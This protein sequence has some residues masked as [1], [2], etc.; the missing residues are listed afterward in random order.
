MCSN[1]LVLFQTYCVNDNDNN[2]NYSKSN[3]NNNNDNKIKDVIL[4]VQC[5]INLRFTEY[6]A[7]VY[8]S[9]HLVS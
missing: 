2:G 4:E 1:V 8:F 7:K 6:D 3:D 9:E 5:T